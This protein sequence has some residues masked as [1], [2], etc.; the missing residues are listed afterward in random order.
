MVEGKN[1]EMLDCW[2]LQYLETVHLRLD[3][4][5]SALQALGEGRQGK[6]RM[7]D[8]LDLMGPQTLV[9]LVAEYRKEMGIKDAALGSLELEGCQVKDLQGLQVWKLQDTLGRVVVALDPKELQKLV[10]LVVEYRK[11]MD[12]N[13]AVLGSLDLEKIFQV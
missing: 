13:I 12:R 7:D 9:A 10:A 6:G 1:A 5:V 11:E 8:A 4:Q 2:G 3:Y